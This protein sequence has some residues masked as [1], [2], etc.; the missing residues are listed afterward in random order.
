M[1]NFTLVFN[2]AALISATFLTILTI[3]V[4]KKK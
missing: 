1:N 3:I 2:L 4:V